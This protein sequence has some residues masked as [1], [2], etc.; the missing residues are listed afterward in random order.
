MYAV[1]KK[2]R[3]LGYALRSRR[4]TG[5][6]QGYE[7]SATSCADLSSMVLKIQIHLQKFVLVRFCFDIVDITRR[8]KFW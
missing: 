2:G 4:F 5:Q 8:A 1:F 3:D 6:P 7:V